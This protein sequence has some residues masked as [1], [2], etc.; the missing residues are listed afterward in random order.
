MSKILENIKNLFFPK[1]L[2]CVICGR[3]KA[4]NDDFNICEDCY[5][6]LELT[7]GKKVCNRCGKII[8]HMGDYCINCK[9]RE[10]HFDTARSYTLYKSPVSNLIKDYKFYGK[11]YLHTLFAEMLKRTYEYYEMKADFI[12]PVPIHKNILNKRKYNHASL[13]AENF[14]KKVNVPFNE[15]VLV[16][17]KDTSLQAELNGT[18]RKKNLVGAFK[19]VDKKSVLGKD[20]LLVDDIITTNST[21]NEC[22]KMLKQAGAKSVSAI[23]IAYV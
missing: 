4:K 6:N 15:N 16:K 23:L 14:S 21:I 12:V 11:K 18:D 20:I 8:N 22:S 5:K 1:N 10:F 3:D 2:K 13:L 17:T 7:F 9:N 19:V